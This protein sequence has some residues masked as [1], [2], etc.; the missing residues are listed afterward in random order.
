MYK[1]LIADDE[2]MECK[3]LEKMIRDHFSE[4]TLLPS[5]FNGIELLHS[6]D[7]YHPDIAVID[8]AMPG[9]NG[10]DALEILRLKK[11]SLKVIVVSA[12]S[13]FEY[14]KKALNLGASEY[15]LK[16]VDDKEFIDTLRRTVFSLDQ[17]S[18]EFIRQ[19][20]TEVLKQEICRLWENILLSDIMLG[21]TLS[22]D[23]ENYLDSLHCVFTGGIIFTAQIT[24]ANKDDLN[25]ATFQKIYG[26]FLRLLKKV[27]RCFSKLCHSALIVCILPEE[28][29]MM[30]DTYQETLFHLFGEMIEKISFHG[31]QWLIGISD[32]K[33]DYKDLPAAYQESK[34]ATLSKE[35]GIFFYHMQTKGNPSAIW[36]PSDMLAFF[37]AME[38]HNQEACSRILSQMFHKLP[39]EPDFLSYQKIF[40]AYFLYCIFQKYSFHEW[41]VSIYW[42]SLF[43]KETTPQLEEYLLSLITPLILPHADPSPVNKHMASSLHFI[44]KYFSEDLSLEQVADAV[45]ITSFYLSRLFK[46]ESGK[47]FLEILTNYRMTKALE[48]LYTGQ[49]SAQEISEKIGYQNASYFYKLFKKQ[50]GITIGEFKE[51]IHL[52]KI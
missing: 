50:T 9:L 19:D 18:R 34:L 13:K 52:M 37:L 23:W 49:Y 51:L 39:S 31:V 21:F 44:E 40:A 25:E 6:I 7:H 42:K 2:M 14:A 1:I 12:Y 46:Q 17:Q 45:G 48:F 32:W 10:L 11:R 3:V 20:E 26:E 16:P 33:Y 47:T 43:E 5:V 22:S 27:C 24:S 15:L 36:H 8:I 35:C 28:H 41:Y 4:L 30:R 38:H 29:S